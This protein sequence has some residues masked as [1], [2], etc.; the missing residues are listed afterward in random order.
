M[1]SMEIARIAVLAKIALLAEI[2]I[3]CENHDFQRNCKG[4][5]SN[6]ACW[7]SLIFLR[8]Y[9]DYIHPRP[10]HGAFHPEIA[11]FYGFHA[12]RKNRGFSESRTLAEIVMSCENHDFQRNY[13]GIT[14]NQ[15]CRKSL[16]FLWKYQ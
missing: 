15:A 1:G 6:Q 7:K 4:I 14:S 2:V 3:S 11:D 16:I 12:T 10:R 13:K 5:T 8:K 9:Q